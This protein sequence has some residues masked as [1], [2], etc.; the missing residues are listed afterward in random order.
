MTWTT[1][2]APAEP[3]FHFGGECFDLDVDTDREILRF[4]LSQA[5]YREARGVAC[6]QALHTAPSLDVARFY[7]RHA[8]QELHHLVL[9]ADVFRELGLQPQRPHWVTRLLIFHSQCYPLKVLLEHTIGARM[10]HDIVR[11]VLIQTLSESDPRV[12]GSLPA[13]L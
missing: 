8:R 11:D 9:L 2:L 12:V 3:G 6:G 1:P 4:M 7:I 10:V 13:L 5:L